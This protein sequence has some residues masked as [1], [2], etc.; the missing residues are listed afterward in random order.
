LTFTFCISSLLILSL[1][2]KIGMFI[3]GLL[4]ILCIYIALKA[5]TVRVDG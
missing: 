1:S 4:I 3:L 5:K 2:A